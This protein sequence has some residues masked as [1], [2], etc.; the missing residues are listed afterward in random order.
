MHIL[1]PPC[2]SNCMQFLQ[3]IIPNFVNHTSIA[4]CVDYN[5][6]ALHFSF[7]LLRS[8]LIWSWVLILLSLTA[9][10]TWPYHC[11]KI[12]IICPVKVKLAQLM[13][14]ALLGT[15]GIVLLIVTL[16]H[17]WKWVINVMSQLLFTQE[18]NPFYPQQLEVNFFQV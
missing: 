8:S 15:K 2:A 12:L 17:R 1:C 14:W 9:F 6:H 18:R 5:E 3:Y 11:S 13:S 4:G 7:T 16:G 10:F